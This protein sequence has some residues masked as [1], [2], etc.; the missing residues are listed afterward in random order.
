MSFAHSTAPAPCCICQEKPFVQLHHFGGNGGM[1]MKPSDY[2]VARL[3]MECHIAYDM[4]EK[5]LLRNGHFDQLIAMQRDALQLHDLWFEK[6]EQQKAKKL[7]LRCRSCEHQENGE[8]CA[9]MVH[10]E[11]PIECA[12]DELVEQIFIMNPDNMDEARE[13]FIQWA[14]KRS[15]N[16]L[17][18]CM[19]SLSEIVGCENHTEAKFLAAQALK[20]AGVEGVKK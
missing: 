14:N 13:W 1:S 5:T 20:V 2:M 7:M 3:C 11:P 15:T 17:S 16:V 4:K 18:F 19:E 12:L 6:I 9:T 10:M 8:C